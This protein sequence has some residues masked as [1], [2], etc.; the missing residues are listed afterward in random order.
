MKWLVPAIEIRYRRATASND[1][2]SRRLSSAFSG[3][4]GIAVLAVLVDDFQKGGL[5]CFMR[6]CVR[7]VFVHILVGKLH[8][9]FVA[10]WMNVL[11]RLF[12]RTLAGQDFVPR[13]V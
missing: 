9:S 8:D 6:G 2:R 3:S 10:G 12:E 13:F 5:S 7:Q 1:A 4:I 11:R